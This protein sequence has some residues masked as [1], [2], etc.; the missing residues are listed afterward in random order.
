MHQRTSEQRQ[1][2][3]RRVDAL[4]VVPPTGP[5]RLAHQSL[6]A[7][8]TDLADA[9]QSVPC[10]GPGP[11]PGPGPSR[12]LWT[13]EVTDDLVE[14]AARCRE[15]CPVLALCGAYADAAGEKHHVW[16]GSVRATTTSA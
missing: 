4:A 5:A 8:L 9:G 7:A 6:S 3:R 12:H 1:R 14:A 13:S 11:G 10:H 16:G 2:N 15:S